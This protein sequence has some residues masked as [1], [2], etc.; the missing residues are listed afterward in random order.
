M[1]PKEQLVIPERSGIHGFHRK[2]RK[3]SNGTVL[4]L[5]VP[6]SSCSTIY[7]LSVSY[8]VKLDRVL[9]G[10]TLSHF[11]FLFLFFSPTPIS[12]NPAPLLTL[13]CRI[14][15]WGEGK[16]REESFFSSF[17]TVRFVRRGPWI[18]EKVVSLSLF[19]RWKDGLWSER[20]RGHLS[21]TNLFQWIYPLRA[22]FI[23]TIESPLKA[24]P[25]VIY[26][27]HDIL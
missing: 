9:F 3:K 26:V 5:S 18:L 20:W 24:F 1:R 21:R 8:N 7:C 4:C 6:L 17:V 2:S 23:S 27:F 19:L 13:L 10:I 15:Y 25:Q 12:R 22:V 14:K 11:S 16:R